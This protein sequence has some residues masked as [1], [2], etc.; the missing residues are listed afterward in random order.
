MHGYIA[1]F[2]Y[3]YPA[4]GGL[5]G[6][7]SSAHIR[8]PNNPPTDQDLRAC[9]ALLLEDSGGDWTSVRINR[10]TPA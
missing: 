6:G 2:T 9:E 5:A 8:V 3:R 1:Y 7:S 4:G 10:V